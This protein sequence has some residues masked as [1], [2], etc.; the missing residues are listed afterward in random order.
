[1][2]DEDEEGRGERAGTM[3]PRGMYLLCLFMSRFV[4][5]QTLSENFDAHFVSPV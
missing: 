3:Y 1:L 2:Q 5:A 4:S